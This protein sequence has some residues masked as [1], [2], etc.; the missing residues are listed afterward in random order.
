MI[1]KTSKIVL[2]I[3][4]L[5]MCALLS[6]CTQNA[7]RGIQ[8]DDKKA[9][10]GIFDPTKN[11][12]GEFT[13]EPE[14]EFDPGE[15]D[16][17][18]GT[19]DPNSITPPGEKTD[20]SIKA[21]IPPITGNNGNTANTGNN[22]NTGNTG[23]TGNSGTGGGTTPPPSTPDT[24]P[25]PEKVNIVL[26]VTPILPM[27]APQTSSGTKTPPAGSENTTPPT[28]YTGDKA[29]PYTFK[30]FCEKYPDNC[31]NGGVWVL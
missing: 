7:K 6:A 15:K 1:L 3:N 24:A 4:A 21:S 28:S 16:P 10:D 31:S 20:A 12:A 14:T 18:S 8:V 23:N 5:S 9:G 2:F 13:P 29:S 30:E 27:V 19:K 22:G 17:N 11:G 26:T 25:V